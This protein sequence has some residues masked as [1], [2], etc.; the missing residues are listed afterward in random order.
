MKGLF[1]DTRIKTCKGLFF[2]LTLFLF[3]LFFFCP[4]NTRAHGPVS[5][6]SAVVEVVEK[7]GPAV[8]NINTEEIV[9]KRPNP[10]YGTGDPFFD[11]FFSIF[12]P[13]RD[14][15][16]Q[17]L[18]SGVIINSSGYILTNE[19]VISHA[20]SITVKL[21]D[22]R[23]FSAKLIGADPRTDIA[24][25][26][27]D[28]KTPLPF[29]KMGQSDDLLI[30]ETVIAI[31]N[32]FGLSHTVTTGIISAINRN[33][34]AGKYKVYT[35]FIQLDASINPGNSGGPLLNVNGELVGINTA[36][37]RKGEGIGFAI[38]INRAER[39]VDDL[40]RYGEVQQGWLGIF[41]QSLTPELVDF[42][43]IPNLRGVLISKI[44]KNS[45]A[46]KAG[47][48]TGDVILA[49]EGSKVTSPK[50]FQNMLSSYTAGDQVTI[51]FINHNNKKKTI[52]LVTTPIPESMA[53]D[54]A[55]SWL[56]VQ[57]TEITSDLINRYNLFTKSGVLITRLGKAS[58]MARVGISPGDII[59]QINK[60]TI[61][62]MPDFRKAVIE[63]MK[64]N[65]VLFLIQRGRYGYY[66]TIEP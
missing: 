5:R 53:E 34:K 18:G 23:E 29:V 16:R 44:F 4:S 45:P 13:P 41:V 19:H 32:P 61:G 58:A 25:I 36:I 11:K 56:G 2:H 28:A 20:S 17:S 30:G 37:F 6:R 9:S 1:L 50:D 21:I 39:I 10:F 31:G 14:Y 27:I 63:A 42:F 40:I 33:I 35:D 7:V 64:R 57:V 62:G 46:D 47:I 24:V 55:K 65:S 66:V 3:F 49:I 48:A 59:R 15:R 8:V 12:K 43:E 51:D 26:K 60:Q 54:L 52:Q 22:N 38:P